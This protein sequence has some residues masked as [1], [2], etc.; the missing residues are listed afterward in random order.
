MSSHRDL[1]QN[2][3]NLEFRID[4]LESSEYFSKKEIQDNFITREE[5]R[6][7]INRYEEKISVF[8]RQIDALYNIQSHGKPY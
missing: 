3:S 4:E 5:V 7:L 8:K 1:E 2:I 6:I